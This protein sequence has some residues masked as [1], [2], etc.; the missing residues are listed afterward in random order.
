MHVTAYLKSPTEHKTGPVAIL[1]G[2]QRS[3]KQAAFEAICRILLGDQQDH[4][5]PRRIAGKEIELRTVC[6]ELRTVSMWGEQRVVFVDDA[7][8]FVSQNRASLEKYL[9]NPAKKSVLV[10]SVKS[11]PKST[12]LAKLVAKIGLDLEC[13][14]LSGRG[15]ISWLIDE[16][17][18]RHGKRLSRDAALLTVELAG[19]DLG[20][21]DQEL[22]KLAAYVG[23][24]KRIDPKDISTLVGGWKTETTWAMTGALRDGDLGT[25]LTCLDK[26]LVAGEAPLKILGGINFVFRKVARAAALARQGTPLSTALK[27]AGVFPR[28][29]N[30]SADYLRRL[31]QSASKSLYPWLLTADG[32]LKGNSRMPGRMQLE[33]LLVQLSGK[34]G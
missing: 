30:A 9:N 21:L 22:A 12:R 3:L 33:Y 15:L 27:Q 5:G 17:Q 23:E 31:G 1:S 20:L 2:T 6:D 10:L 24:R 16:C 11:W 28:E 26:L 7:D 13:A 25:A 18:E 4:A 8:D 29:I 34:L 14:E 19:S 32:N